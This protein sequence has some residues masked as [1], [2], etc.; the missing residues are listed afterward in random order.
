MLPDTRCE[1]PDTR[2][3]VRDDGIAF[4]SSSRE[5]C[6]IMKEKTSML[7]IS[8]NVWALCLL[9]I[10]LLWACGEQAPLESDE[11]VRPV[12]VMAVGAGD[13][14]GARSFPGSVQATDQV[15]LSFRVDGPL[16][17]FPINEGDLVKKGQV[18]ARIDP[19]DYR[20]RLDAARA[21][22]E[23]TDADFRRYA[24]LYEKDAVS[25]AQL[26]QARAA[27]D[28]ARADLDDAEA[29]LADTSLRAP[30]SARVG[31]TFV[32]NFQDVVAKEAI[33]SLVNI[34]SVDV[35]V[36]IPENLIARFRGTQDGIR[37][38]V[39][40]DA[41]PGR[42]FDAK[43]KEVA[44][45][46]DPKT[47]TFRIT[48][49]LPQP[50]GINAL[51]GMTAGVTRHAAA[52]EAQPIAVPA[53]AVFADESGRSFVWVVDPGGNTVGRRSVETGD[54]TGTDSVEIA[55]GLSAGEVIAI[56][57]ASRLRDGMEIKPVEEVSGL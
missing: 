40:F 30:F 3:E 57:A 1:M 56:S 53:V 15:D 34:T 51:P 33:L 12:K 38:T 2:R 24:A 8:H 50:E 45:Q 27:R 9:T 35:L 36:D 18:L 54:L 49:T 22:M 43:V 16:I 41:A 5:G 13:G 6:P 7:K 25:K 17:T 39:T 19:R 28:V 10:P 52:G 20:I 14:G 21:H 44:A 32:E 42:A 11:I 4:V 26:D 48:I 29:A 23:R 37:L 55:A 46:A 31:E 47:Q